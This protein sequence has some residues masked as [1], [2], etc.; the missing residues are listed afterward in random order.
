MTFSYCPMPRIFVTED[1]VIHGDFD[2]N[3]KKI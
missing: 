3:K 1:T 2:R